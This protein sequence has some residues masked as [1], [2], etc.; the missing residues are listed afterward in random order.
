MHLHLLPALRIAAPAWAG[1]P[2]VY[3]AHYKES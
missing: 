1:L 3:D 2:V